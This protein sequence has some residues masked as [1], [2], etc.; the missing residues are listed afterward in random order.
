MKI[1]NER[2]YVTLVSTIFILLLGVIAVGQLGA[3]Q[4]V[5]KEPPGAEWDGSFTLTTK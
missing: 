4:R 1:G 5:M 3:G 2:S